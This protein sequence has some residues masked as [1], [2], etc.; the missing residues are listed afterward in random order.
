MR[1]SFQHI[2]MEMAMLMA[3][4]STCIRLQVGCVITT[5]DFRKVLSVGYNGNASGLNNGCDSDV[6]GKCGCLHGEEN[7]II[8]CQEPR[9]LP[10]IVFATNMP[11]KMC[12]KRII[13]LGGVVKVYYA[14]EYREPR[15][16]LL[17]AAGIAH[18]HL[19]M[20]P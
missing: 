16:D 1:P 2:Y 8:N 13:N 19:V 14:N 15:L 3:K 5:T 7:A 18:E 20:L 4:R 11:C 9:G 17:D 12:V 10:K 6:P